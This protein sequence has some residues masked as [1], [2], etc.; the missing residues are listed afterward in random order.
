MIGSKKPEQVT[1]AHAPL[2]YQV[3]VQTAGQR[4]G[5]DRR[6]GLAASGQHFGLDFGAVPPTR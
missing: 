1:A 6:A 5:R 4:H 2:A 3:G